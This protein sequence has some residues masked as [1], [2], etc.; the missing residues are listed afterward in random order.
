MVPVSIAGRG[1]MNAPATIGEDTLSEAN[2]LIDG[3][4]RTLNAS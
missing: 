1:D 4:N 2:V 3:S